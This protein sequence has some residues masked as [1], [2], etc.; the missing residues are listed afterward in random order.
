MAEVICLALTELLLCWS[1]VARPVRWTA[2]P[3]WYMEGVRPN[4][5]SNMRPVA[6]GNPDNDGTFGHPDVTPN[7]PRWIG[8]RIWCTGG[9]RPAVSGRSIW[10]QR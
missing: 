10:C 5:S 3:G 4:G 6:G 7:D 9:S 1:F 2:P 8:V